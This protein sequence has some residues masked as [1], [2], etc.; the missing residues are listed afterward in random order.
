[1]A[2]AD[3]HAGAVREAVARA[4]AEDLTPLG[5]ITSALLPVGATAVAHFVPRAEGVLAGVACAG[6]TF[7]QLDPAVE[8]TW[9]AADGDR[10]AAGKVIGSVS[11]SMRTEEHQSELQA[12]MRHTAAD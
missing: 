4:L 8:L 2:V 6:E 10:I 7:A 12:L 5:D 11:G 3:P 9:A 1:M